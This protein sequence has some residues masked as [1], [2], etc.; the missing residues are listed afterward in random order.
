[1]LWVLRRPYVPCR[2][3]ISQSSFWIFCTPRTSCDL[4]CGVRN[5]NVL[6]K[7]VSGANVQYWANV[8]LK[9]N[10][11]MGGANQTLRT[12]NLGFFANGKTMLVGLAVTHPSSGSIR[13]A[14]SVVG[15]VASVD[16]Q[17]V[18]WPA[19]IRIQPARQEMVSELDGFSMGDPS[20]LTLILAGRSEADRCMHG[21][22]KPNLRMGYCSIIQLDK[23]RIL[24]R[25]AN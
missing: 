5:V 19:D 18:Q 3:N 12:S 13:S 25:V 16:A 15:I 2:K 8:G 23:C 1:M 24:L 11:K 7:K 4:R 6:S 20:T 21:Q 17:L 9:I 10:P 14:P 22:I